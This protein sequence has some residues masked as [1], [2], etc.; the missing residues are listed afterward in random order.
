MKQTELIQIDLDKV[1][2]SKMGSKARY[3]PRFLV[4]WL[5]RTICQDE[6]NGM[7]QRFYPNTGADFSRAALRDLKIKVELKNPEKLPSF[8]DRRVIFVSNHPLGGLDGIALISLIS[9]IRAMPSRPPNGWLLTN[10]TRLSS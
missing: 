10:I 1:L 8:D 6:L 4:N 9:A 3:V 7:L 5:K 2:E